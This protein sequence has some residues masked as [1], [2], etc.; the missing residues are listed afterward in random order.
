MKAF[1]CMKYHPHHS[2]PSKWFLQKCILKVFKTVSAM[3]Y[4]VLD[5]YCCSGNG[6]ITWKMFNSN[7]KQK[8]LK[9]FYLDLVR[10]MTEFKRY[11]IISVDTLKNQV[12]IWSPVQMLWK[13][14][15]SVAENPKRNR[16]N[17][18]TNLRKT[19]LRC[20]VPIRNENTLL[21]IDTIFLHL[22]VFHE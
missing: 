14:A 5:Y 11:Y 13:A 15:L 20:T 21:T 3:K 1:S 16:Y 12:Q 6:T 10:K 17:G 18:D 8:H 4:T 2:S 7:C 19:G 9:S 22:L